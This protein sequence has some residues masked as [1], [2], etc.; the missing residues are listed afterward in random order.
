MPLSTELVELL[1]DTQEVLIETRSGEDVTRTVIWVGVS[2]D[3][4]YVRS[5]RGESGRWYQRAIA[6]DDVTLIIGEFRLELSAVSAN[7]P[8]SIEAA[9]EGFRRKYSNS[10]WLTPMLLPEVLGTTLRLESRS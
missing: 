4:V 9:S 3:T 10:G 1:A 6:N 7:D 5:V 8:A 2:D